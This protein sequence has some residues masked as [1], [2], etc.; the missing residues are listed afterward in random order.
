MKGFDQCCCLTGDQIICDLL[1]YCSFLWAVD[2]EHFLPWKRHCLSLNQFGL[3][4][5]ISGWQ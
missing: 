5:T 4:S 3:P 2:S 1:T